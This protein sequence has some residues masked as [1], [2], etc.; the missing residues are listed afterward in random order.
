MLDDNRLF[1]QAAVASSAYASMAAFTAAANMYTSFYPAMNT[2]PDHPVN[3]FGSN[4]KKII[5]MSDGANVSILEM[6]RERLDPNISVTL[7]GLDLWK[8][9]HSMGTEMIITKYVPSTPLLSM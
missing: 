6:K 4:G 7:E 1:Q 2:N 8:R 3:Y 5:R 9:F